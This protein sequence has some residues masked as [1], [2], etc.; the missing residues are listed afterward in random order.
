MRLSSP[1]DV[2]KH[3][4]LH[5]V[6]RSFPP[7][8]APKYPKSSKSMGWP[9]IRAASSLLHKLTVS[10]PA[11]WCLEV[12]SAH[13]VQQCAA[14]AVKHLKHEHHQTPEVRDSQSFVQVLTITTPLTFRLAMVCI[15]CGD[16]LQRVD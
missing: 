16:V 14:G 2:L 5:V 3:A 12:V 4:M 1:V 6:S 10:L 13:V 9:S 11:N 8:A 7:K 15:C